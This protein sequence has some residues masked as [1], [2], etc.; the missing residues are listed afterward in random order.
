VRQHAQRVDIVLLAELLKF[1]RVVALMAIKDQQL[2]RSNHLALYMLDKVLQPL[3]SY[4]VGCPAI[5]AHSN[6][7]VTWDVFLGPDRQVVLTGKDDK[8]WDS[9]ASSVDPL[10]HCRPLAIARLDRLWPA[11][12]L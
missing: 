3:N 4:L 7:P 1:Q 12:P 9:P 11:S 2:M 8:Q 10:D 5:I 6:S